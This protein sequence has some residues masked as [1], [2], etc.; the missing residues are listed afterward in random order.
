MRS[1]IAT[2]DQKN[3][4]STVYVLDAHTR[5]DWAAQVNIADS[6][7]SRTTFAV[8]SES[9]CLL[10]ERYEVMMKRKKKK[11]INKPS[12]VR[13]FHLSFRLRFD[14]CIS[15]FSLPLSTWLQFVIVSI[16]ILDCNI[17][18]LHNRT[19]FGSFWTSW[20]SVASQMKCIFARSYD[21]QEKTC[22][23]INTKIETF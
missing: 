12:S 18:F 2:V 7:R 4:A 11:R 15:L 3:I 19:F 13:C 6:N 21:S 16:V 9:N 1:C 20:C 22:C 5:N 8:V 14:K 23:S 10:T 17:G